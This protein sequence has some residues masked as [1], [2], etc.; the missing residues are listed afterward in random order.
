VGF[1]FG[2]LVVELA[3]FSISFIWAHEIMDQREVM[4]FKRTMRGYEESSKIIETPCS[5]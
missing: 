4:E 1:R 5:H 2:K 3:L